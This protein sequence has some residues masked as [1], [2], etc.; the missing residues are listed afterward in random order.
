M[1]AEVEHLLLANDAWYSVA[2]EVAGVDGVDG[3]DD[4]ANFQESKCWALGFNP[5]NDVLLV[6]WRSQTKPEK[7]KGRVACE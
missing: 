5:S 1:D 3:L 7:G 6:H 2:G 4:I